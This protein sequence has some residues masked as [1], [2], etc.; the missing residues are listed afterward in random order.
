MVVTITKEYYNNVMRLHAEIVDLI[1]ERAT[2]MA[3]MQHGRH[4]NGTCGETDFDEEDGKLL[5][6]FEEYW[7]SE[8][9]YDTYHVPIE[10]LFDPDWAEKYEVFL[11]EDGKRREEEKIQRKKRERTYHVVENTEEWDLQE[12]ERLKAKYGGI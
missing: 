7:C 4:P 6:Q 10:Y 2:A 11:V 12:Y 9:N 8:S 3:L 5:V 1:L